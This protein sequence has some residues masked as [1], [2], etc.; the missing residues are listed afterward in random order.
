MLRSFLKLLAAVAIM[1]LIA[2]CETHDR[3]NYRQPLPWKSHPAS[4]QSAPVVT[5]AADLT[6]PVLPTP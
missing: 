6:A 5:P 4:E 1:Q 3:V 2:G